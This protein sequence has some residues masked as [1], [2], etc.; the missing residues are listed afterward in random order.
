M[1]I[2]LEVPELILFHLPRV[3]PKAQISLLKAS[4]RMSEQRSHVSSSCHY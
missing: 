3:V 2:R 1:V 4:D